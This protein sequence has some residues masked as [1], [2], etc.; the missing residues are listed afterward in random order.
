VA[1]PDWREVRSADA[2]EGGGYR[3]R[4]YAYRPY[5]QGGSVTMDPEGRRVYAL[6]GRG[7]VVVLDAGTLK[8]ERRRGVC[9]RPE[10]LVVNAAGQAFVACRDGQV[11]RVDADRNDDDIYAADVEDPRGELGGRL[12][13]IA[14]S[15]DGEALMVTKEREPEVVKLSARTLEPLWRRALPS[16]P[17]GVAISAGGDRAVIA[18]LTSPVSTVVD[19]KRG[20]AASAPL[21]R[22]RDG[23]PS[24]LLEHAEEGLVRRVAGGA[25]AVA[26]SPGGTRAFV[27]YLLKNDGAEVDDFIPGCY[28]NGA[29]LPVAATVAAVDIGHGLVQRPLP[30]PSTSPGV[31]DFS[32][33]SNLGLLGVVRAA[34]HDPVRSRLYA[35][36]EASRMLASFDTSKADPTS[37]PL[38]FYTLPGPA[39]GVVVDPEGKRAFVHLAMQ[40][41]LVVLDLETD[42][43]EEVELASS[44][45]ELVDRGRVLFHTANDANLSSLTGIACS[46]CHLDGESDGVTWRLDGKPLQTPVLAARHYDHGALRWHGDSPTL[47]HAIGEAVT[48]LGGKGLSADD[49]QALQAFLEQ[50]PEMKPPET[51]EPPTNGA[52]IFA[53]VGCTNC[54]DP[55]R[56]YSD[57][58]MHTV[59]GKTIR[60]PSLVGVSRSAPYYHDGRVTTLRELL[61]RHE[62]GNPMSRAASLEASER[63]ALEA[64]L[65]GL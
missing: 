45:D 51:S 38:R 26:A 39:K 27:P 42:S 55:K 32:G 24:E 64:F 23:W 50:S 40:E 46:T 16:Q 8:I 52:Q 17:R 19:V 22:V 28:A 35:V 57:N 44:S 37:N 31:A 54:H 63:R 15:P 62:A 43:T 41:K 53:Q 3:L 49:T 34:F 36:G 48:R 60:T 56:D 13:G 29:Q 20:Y 2:E 5:L 7:D 6:S 4:T 33:I 10:Q 14:L 12:F 58:E 21:P 30:L 18:H 65:R 61:T 9:S 11:V 25:Y 59:R 47:E 1:A